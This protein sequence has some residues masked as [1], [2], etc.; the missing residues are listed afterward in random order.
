MQARACDI[1]DKLLELS[2]ESVDGGGETELREQ[3]MALT[4][5]REHDH[6]V[7]ELLRKQ[8]ALE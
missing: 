2:G 5:A 1:R 4:R 6:R 8:I 3:V 7:I